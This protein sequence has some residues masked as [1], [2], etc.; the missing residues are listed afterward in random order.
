M[1]LYTYLSTHACICLQAEADEAEYS[2]DQDTAMQ[3]M[4]EI[5]ALQ[6][7][8]VTHTHTDTHTGKRTHTQAR[9]YGC[10]SAPD[11]K[12]AET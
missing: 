12:R 9:T 3:Y 8:D 7:C 6:V 1:L 2:G 4:N 10:G 11:V 5:D